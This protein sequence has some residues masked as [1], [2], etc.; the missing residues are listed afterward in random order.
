M[1]VPVL[2]IHEPVTDLFCRN[3]VKDISVPSHGSLKGILHCTSPI[4]LS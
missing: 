4:T 2:V 3:P 1:G